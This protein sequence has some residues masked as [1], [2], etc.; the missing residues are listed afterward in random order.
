[1]TDISQAKWLPGQKKTKQYYG[2]R[3]EYGWLLS[4]KVRDPRNAMKAV[5]GDELDVVT[6]LALEPKPIERDWR[7]FDETREI[8]DLGRNA[9]RAEEILDGL[10]KEAYEECKLRDRAS[11]DRVHPLRH[12]LTNEGRPNGGVA[13]GIQTGKSVFALVRGMDFADDLAYTALRNAVN[14]TSKAGDDDTAFRKAMDTA[15]TVLQREKERHSIAKDYGHQDVREFAAAIIKNDSYKGA[16]EAVRRRRER[17]DD[18]LAARKEIAA[19]AAAL[20]AEEAAK[21]EAEAPTAPAEAQG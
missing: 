7:R 6:M 20:A 10:R 2:L 18:V 4:P 15:I 11:P 13:H 1:M 14:K 5:W 8:V 17:L 19:R 12:W 9:K 3:N 16:I 21:A